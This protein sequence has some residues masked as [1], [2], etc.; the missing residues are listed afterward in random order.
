MDA[1]TENA[2]AKTQDPKNC[3]LRAVG[4]SEIVSY[5]IVRLPNATTSPDRVC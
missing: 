4:H 1:I 3:A 5:D 2:T